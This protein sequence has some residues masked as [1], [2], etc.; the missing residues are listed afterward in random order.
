[1]EIRLFQVDAFTDVLFHGNPAA[2]C[3][4]TTWL[5]DHLL[6]AIAEENN[7]SETAFYVPEGN[8]YRI[9]WFTP[10]CEVDLCGHATLA[11]AHVLFRHEG[12]SGDTITFASRSGILYV[13]RDS[14]M[15]VLDFPVDTLQR[16][17]LPE[18]L[19]AALGGMPLETW[20]GKDDFLLVYGSQHEIAS[21]DPD[22]GVIGRIPCRGVIVTAPGETVDFVSRFFGPQSGIAEDPVTGSAHTTLVPYWAG[23]LKKDTF[24]AVQLSRRTGRLH[25]RLNRDRV[26]IGGKAITYLAGSI[27]VP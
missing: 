22:F 4:L 20:R 13:H 2:V 9:R 23:R 14:D 12:Q 6:Q 27:T 5:P 17:P 1:M 26:T 11:T 19:D 8:G 7:L 21:M 15:L 24:Q 18:G 3:P 25:C 16:A 10:V